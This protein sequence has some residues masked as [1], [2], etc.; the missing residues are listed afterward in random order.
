[1]P[2]DVRVS[3]FPRDSDGYGVLAKQPK[4]LHPGHGSAL[5]RGKKNSRAIFHTL[6]EP[7]AQGKNFI[8][9]WLAPVTVE[10]LDTRARALH[11]RD[12][13]G[14]I[15]QINISQLE[16]SRFLASQRVTKREKKQTPIARGMRS[17]FFEDGLHLCG[18]KRLRRGLHGWH[19]NLDFLS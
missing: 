2:Q 10:A 15:F 6:A 19:E 14:G 4:K 13:D 12:S 1:M 16:R 17:R 9:N 8:Q 7:G 3:Q 11:P 18:R 5:L